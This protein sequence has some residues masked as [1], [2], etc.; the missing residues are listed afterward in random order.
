MEAMLNFIPAPIALV[1]ML[2]E[3]VTEPVIRVVILPRVVEPTR[4]AVELP[5][6]AV[7]TREAAELPKEAVKWASRHSPFG[8]YT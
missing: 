4:K 1:L 8:G 7:P 6:V 2:R 3:T 5:K